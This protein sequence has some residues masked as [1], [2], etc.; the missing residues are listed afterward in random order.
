[1]TDR[2]ETKISDIAAQYHREMSDLSTKYADRLTAHQMLPG[3]AFHL[4]L[5]LRT[6]CIVE[7]VNENTIRDVIKN[8]MDAGEKSATNSLSKS[9]LR[10]P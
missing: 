1:M 7:R 2:S 4:G 5:M 3:I 10:T 9:R 6:T 8:F